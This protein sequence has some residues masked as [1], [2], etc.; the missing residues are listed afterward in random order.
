M[1]KAKE[2]EAPAADAAPPKKSRKLLVIVAGV[3][4]L[5]VIGGGAYW[6]FGRTDP[7][8]AEAA[9]EEPKEPAALVAL[10]PFVVNLADEGGGR[11]LR[12]TLGLVVNGEEHAKEFA[13]DSVARLKVRSSILEM[14]AQQTAE[15]LITTGGKAELKKAIAERASHD[16]EHLEV[17]DVLFSE[18]IVQ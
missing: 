10:D 14:L 17:T 18:F 9:K 3:V 2:T 15:H 16:A 8:A 7:A 1:S 4:L 12:V 5:A 11:Y 13:E 6:T